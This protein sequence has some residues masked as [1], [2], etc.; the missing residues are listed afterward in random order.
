MWCVCVMD[1]GGSSLVA[2]RRARRVMYGHGALLGL[3]ES[4]RTHVSP[5]G[6]RTSLVRSAQQY[7]VGS[8]KDPVDRVVIIEV[9]A[10]PLKALHG[11]TRGAHVAR[12]V[13]TPCPTTYAQSSSTAVQL[14]EY[15]SSNSPRYKAVYKYSP[16]R[17]VTHSSQLPGRGRPRCA[18]CTIAIRDSIL[19]YIP[20]CVLA[21]LP[22]A[23]RCAR[24]PT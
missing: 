12:V 6:E 17:D 3:F 7:S 20:F 4:V 13:R 9:H 24:T 11:Y 15:A 16:V 19:V 14:Y 18:S 21:L 5:D 2:Q 23:V 22:L 10:D 1:L 8:N